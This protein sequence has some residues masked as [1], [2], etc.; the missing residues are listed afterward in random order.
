MECLIVICINLK[1]LFQTNDETKNKIYS[2]SIK[3]PIISNDFLP[4]KVNE[5]STLKTI[6][7]DPQSKIRE[8]DFYEKTKHTILGNTAFTTSLNKTMNK[9][10]L[11]YYVNND[12]L[13]STDYV[14][15]ST[16]NNDCKSLSYKSELVFP[17]INIE[18]EEYDCLALFVV[19]VT[20]LMA[21]HNNIIKI[22]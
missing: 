2:V 20:K 5:T 10:K 8:T 22:L 9:E 14:N 4:N 15:T 18:N 12:I 19:I 11:Q 6:C 1:N 3:F 21:L 7:R 17:L 13:K 16:I